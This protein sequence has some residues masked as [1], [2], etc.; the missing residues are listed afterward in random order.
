MNKMIKHFVLFIILFCSTQS[1]IAQKTPIEIKKQASNAFNNKDYATA[2]N[3]IN[4]MEKL[5]KQMPYTF[6]SMRIISLYNII[7]DSS[8]NNFQNIEEC[9]KFINNYM[10][11]PNIKYLDNSYDEVIEINN[12]LIKFPNDYD[13]FIKYKDELEKEKTIKIIKDSIANSRKDRLESF[14]KYVNINYIDLGN[15]SDDE[16]NNLFE[17]TK[18]K[19]E[20]IIK[21]TSKTFLKIIGIISFMV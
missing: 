13:S 10:K 9:K 21:E 19:Y 17:S 15:I 16:F 11:I 1:I 12:S 8:I 7:A 4:E 5:Y 3:R 14:S 20:K 6:L 2:L 18:T